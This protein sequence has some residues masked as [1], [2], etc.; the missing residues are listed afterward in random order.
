MPDPL[1]GEGASGQEVAGTPGTGGE[2][3]AP[4]K[5]LPVTGGSSPCAVGQGPS[6]GAGSQVMRTYTE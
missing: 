1:P 2:D 3:P 4:A 6:T 5:S